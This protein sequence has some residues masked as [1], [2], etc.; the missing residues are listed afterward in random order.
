M[1]TLTSFSQERRFEFTSI[2]I[3]ENKVWTEVPRLGEVVI[4]DNCDPRT[5]TLI[6]EDVVV[7]R[8]TKSLIK[9]SRSYTHLYTLIDDD[10]AESNAVLTLEN[11]SYDYSELI[12]RSDETHIKICLTLCKP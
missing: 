8:Y 5:F 1:L 7:T 10:Y 9:Y 12:F 4:C 3:E 11:R 6:I 2:S